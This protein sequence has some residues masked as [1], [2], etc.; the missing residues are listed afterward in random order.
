MA[1]GEGLRVRLSR[2]PGE[3]PKTVLAQPLILPA[4]MRNFGWSEEALHSEYDTVRAGQ[5][6]QPALGPATARRLRAV[7]DVETLTVEWD[8]PWLVERG[9]DPDR[10]YD[11][12]FGVL[13][14][15]K[16]C[17]LLVTPKFGP[18]R[19]LL[20]MDITIRSIA[21]QMREGEADTIYYVLRW[22][23]W[24]RAEGKRRGAGKP[25]LPTTHKLTATD[26]LYSLSMRY[27]YS[28]R[29]ADVIASANAIKGW[30]K[31]T[32]LVQMQRYKVGS[33]LKVPKLPPSSASRAS[34]G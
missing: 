10:V 34:S 17:E 23:E 21:P 12:L 8:A 22:S 4:V 14:S 20:R 18:E 26:T 25:K 16:P 3:T 15:R 32:P 19:P 11:E 5:F 28:A 33:K 29:G 6:S 1:R 7:D 30:G 31:K 24:R 9:I 27:Y 13:R 2:I